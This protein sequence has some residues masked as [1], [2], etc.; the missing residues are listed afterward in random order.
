V[1][2]Y[3]NADEFVVLTIDG[4]SPEHLLGSDGTSPA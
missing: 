3:G 4:Q 1:I 2:Q